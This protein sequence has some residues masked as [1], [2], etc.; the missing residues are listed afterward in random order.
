MAEACDAMRRGVQAAVPGAECIT[1]PLADGGDSTLNVLMSSCGGVCV[2]DIQVLGPL[3]QPILAPYG[4]IGGGKTAV[5]EMAKA[6]GLALLAPDEKDPSR[7]STVGTGQLIRHALHAGAERVVLCIG[8]SATND[9]GVGAARALGYSFRDAQ[10]AEVD[11]VGG[12]LLDITTIDTS[13][14]DP[15]LHKAEFIVACD[16]ENPLCGPTGAAAVYGPQKGARTPEQRE[17]LDR[18]LAHLATLWETQLSGTPANLALLPGAG[19]AGGL[20]GGAIAFFRAKFMRGFDL[21]AHE[22]GLHRQLDGAH[23]VLTGE[24]RVDEQ[25]G[26]GKVPYGV[27]ML[28]KQRGVPVCGIFGGIQDHEGIRKIP[29]LGEGAFFSICGAKGPM[30]L[31]EAMDAEMASALITEQ[32]FNMARLFA[33]G[34]QARNA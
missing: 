29:A 17:L 20:G 15:L 6:S 31:E 12:R 18:G 7:T 8:G 23:L 16:V 10:G 9:G 26:S 27:A 22:A 2:K 28:A 4:L 13:G 34:M 21:V 3:G 24:G 14:V 19:A 11:P 30:T 1:V 25:T 5:I 33:M 32:A